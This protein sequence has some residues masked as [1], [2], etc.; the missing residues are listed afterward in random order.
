MKILYITE[1][2]P[3]YSTPTLGSF[4]MQR[5]HALQE[6]GHEI[7]V[8]SLHFTSVIGKNWILRRLKQLSAL[9]FGESVKEEI[10]PAYNTKTFK[11]H[12]LPVV[13][14]KL[15]SSLAL[16]LSLWRYFSAY[17]YDIVHLHF[18]WYSYPAILAKKYFGLPLIITVHGSDL[19]ED[20]NPAISKRKYRKKNNKIMHFANRVIF[21]SQFLKD[22]AIVYGYKA[23]NSVVIPN[24]INPDLFYPNK[25]NM[26]GHYKN[27]CVAYIGNLYT[28]KGVKRLPLIFYYIKQKYPSISFMIIGHDDSQDGNEKYIRKKLSGLQL[29]NCTRMIEKIQHQKVGEYM[30]KI[31]VLVLPTDNE[32]YP[33]IV[34]EARACG[35]PVVA[36]DV[37]GVPEALGTSGILVKKQT[38]FEVYFAEAVVTLL[39]ETLPHRRVTANIHTWK[40]IIRKEVNVYKSVLECKEENQ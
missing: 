30:R 32:G 19:H 5:I 7:T 15:A 22:T 9:L 16:F 20:L 38:E 37:G 13:K 3:R 33:C 8:L 12:N 35:V 18:L 17:H 29:S 21:V 36:T 6:E 39:N 40:Q 24:G 14:I 11:I 34:V 10:S 28:A 23:K 26:N 1:V 2:F 27:K 25:K 31:D 4:T